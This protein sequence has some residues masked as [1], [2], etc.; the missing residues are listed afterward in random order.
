MKLIVVFIAMRTFALHVNIANC[1]VGA[2]VGST[3][4]L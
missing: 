3:T 2:A 1:V 4:S